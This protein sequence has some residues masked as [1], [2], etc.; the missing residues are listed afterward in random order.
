MQKK[1]KKLKIVILMAG[2]GQRFKDE[3]FSD[4]KPFIA[5]KN[6]TFIEWTL[7]SFDKKNDFLLVTKNE[8]LNDY[9]DKLLE[10]KTKY[11]KLDVIGIKTPTTGAASSALNVFGH[12]DL[13]QPILFVDVDNF[14]LDKEAQKFVDFSL[15]QQTDGSLSVF[16]SNDPKFSFIQKENDLVSKTV[17]KEVVS[18]HAISGLYFFS[19]ARDFFKYNLEMH[20]LKRMTRGEFYISNIYNLMIEDGKKISWFQIDKEKYLSFGTPIQ[21]KENINK[22]K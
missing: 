11:R 16:D 15:N 22:L 9:N 18:N 6:K 13:D 7:S 21:M 14:Y 5:V 8:F 12:V 20:A 1:D 2:E 10:L 19:T 4:P 3:G 17:E